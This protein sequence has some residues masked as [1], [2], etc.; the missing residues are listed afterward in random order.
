[1]D[2][3]DGSAEGVYI[4]RTP[5]VGEYFGHGV[6][7]ITLVHVIPTSDVLLS[8]LYG[9]GSVDTEAHPKIVISLPSSRTARV[10]AKVL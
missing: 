2:V 7:I 10:H 1:M 3:Q 4:L 6:H 8:N 9:C 5:M